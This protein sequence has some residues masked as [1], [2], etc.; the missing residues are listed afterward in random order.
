[1]CSI[2]SLRDTTIQWITPLTSKLI[3]IGRH[4]DGG[5]PLATAQALDDHDD[6][7]GHDVRGDRYP[8]DVV[9]D[10]GMPYDDLTDTEFEEFCF[11]LMK[12]LGFVNVDWRKGTGLNASPSDNGRDIVAE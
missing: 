9:N 4:V 2:I 7:D 5:S 1:M 3:S 12:E 10:A 8:D 6:R 11:E